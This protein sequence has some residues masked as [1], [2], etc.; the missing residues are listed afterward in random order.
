[1]LIISFCC[2]L[3]KIEQ[4]QGLI[5]QNN[6]GGGIHTN[7]FFYLHTG[8]GVIAKLLNGFR[9][10]LQKIICQKISKWFHYQSDLE[11]LN[12]ATNDRITFHLCLFSKLV[13]PIIL[14]FTKMN[15]LRSYENA[16]CFTETTFLCLAIFKFQNKITK[17]KME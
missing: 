10:E 11:N 2:K 13:S 4:L 8:F 6:L 7:L 1:M 16:F 17:L 5:Q 14:H 3:L 9:L 12:S 15:P